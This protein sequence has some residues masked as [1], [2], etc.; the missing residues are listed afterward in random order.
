M[1][2]ATLYALFI[3]PETLPKELRDKSVKFLDKKHFT[4]VLKVVRKQPGKKNNLRRL[5]A[6]NFFMHVSFIG[7]YTVTILFLLDKPLCWSPLDIGLFCAERFFFLGVGAVIGVKLLSKC[8]KTMQIVYF[9]LLSYVVSLVLF[10]FADTA[11]LVCSGKC[12]KV[13]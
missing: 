13:L 6:L 8:F 11:A 9:G 3:M 2:G 7:A 12:S 1:I 4:A 10:A 5:I